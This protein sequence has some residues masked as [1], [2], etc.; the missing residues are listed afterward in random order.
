MIIIK[1]LYRSLPIGVKYFIR[2]K[3]TNLLKMIHFGEVKV[4][5]DGCEYFKSA[6]GTLD[7][8]REAKG[9]E[10][11]EPEFVKEFLN[12]VK[13][14][15]IIYDIGANIGLYSLLAS[16]I[17]NKSKIYAFEPDERCCTI[18]EKSKQL[19]D[20]KNIEILQCCIGD[21][22]GKVEL[23][24][25]GTTGHFISLATGSN[26]TVVK[27]IFTLD[28]LVNARTIIPPQLI[29]IDIEG[30]ES[31]AIRGMTGTIRKYKPIIM[32]E[33]HEQLLSRYNE[34][35][36]GLL[37]EISTLDYRT[38]LLRMPSI[39]APTRH[40]QIHMIFLPS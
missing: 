11:Y 15:E 18:I 30:F 33:I 31:H 9:F 5:I 38:H 34:S 16:S 37:K 29:K 32:I 12:Q 21:T 3:Y 10:H 35:K 25:K 22:N 40:K 36:E 8:Y 26:N 7:D 13:R 14:A 1:N 39:G 27:D 23:V 4:S 6:F 24:T 2:N 19:N 17:N 28:G 20:Y